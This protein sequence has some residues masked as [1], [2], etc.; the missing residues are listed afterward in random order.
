MAE[1]RALDIAGDVAFIVAC[2]VLAGAAVY[3]ALPSKPVS[4]AAVDRARVGTAA[5]LPGADFSRSPMT[6]LVVISTSCR[7]CEASVPFY[8]QLA[9]RDKADPWSLVFVGLEDPA[10]V[11]TYL[12]SHDIADVAVRRLTPELGVRATPTLLIVDARGTIRG[13]WNG[14]LQKEQEEEALRLLGSL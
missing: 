5:V 10:A 12:R 1:R 4:A 14:V 2:V 6:A 3:R 13:A 8:Q 9:Q 11:S 7:F